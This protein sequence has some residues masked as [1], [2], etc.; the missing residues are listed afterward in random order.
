MYQS[1]VNEAIIPEELLWNG[2]PADRIGDYDQLMEVID[3]E[4][5]INPNILETRFMLPKP[6]KAVQEMQAQGYIENW[7]CYLSDAFSAKELTVL[8]GQSVTIKDS[9]AYG[10]IM[11]QGH[12]KMGVWDIETPA[13]IRYGQLTN[14]EF[15]VSEKAAMEGVK[16]TNKSTTD[17]IVMLKHFGPG[18]PDMGM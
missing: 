10:L 7:V 4:L 13:L 15:F 17:R 11:M 16:I 1:L 3:W 9:A 5:N 18:N 8:P 14:D 2:T 6:V 12:G